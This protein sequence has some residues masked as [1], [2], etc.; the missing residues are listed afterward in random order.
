MSQELINYFD[1]V[2]EA[3]KDPKFD[4]F[5]REIKSR[6][7]DYDIALTGE[8]L[9]PLD[10]DNT[11]NK[12]VQNRIVKMQLKK[13]ALIDLLEFLDEEY[14]KKQIIEIREQMQETVLEDIY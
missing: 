7:R 6:L 14:L 11:I 9:V 1:Q 2:L 10:S 5:I 12:D 4:I 8:V 13:S 3:V